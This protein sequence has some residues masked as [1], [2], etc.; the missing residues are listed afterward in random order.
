M[1]SH[2]LNDGMHVQDPRISRISSRD[3]EDDDFPLQ[4]MG[5]L[6]LPCFIK[7]TIAGLLN[8]AAEHG[9]PNIWRQGVQ[10][11]DPLPP[12]LATGL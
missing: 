12:L 11:F 10:N 8:I 3:K 2:P 4:K 6:P 1:G 7:V 9:D 5:D